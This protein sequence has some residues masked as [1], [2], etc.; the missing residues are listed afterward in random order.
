MEGGKADYR[1]SSRKQEGRN[2]QR[3]TDREIEREKREREAEREVEAERK[4]LEVVTTGRR[5]G[6]SL[7]LEGNGR[8]KVTEIR[9]STLPPLLITLRGTT[10]TVPVQLVLPSST[11]STLRPPREVEGSQ[12]GSLSGSRVY[13][14]RTGRKP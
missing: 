2:T 11:F 13:K 6:L 3:E 8:L 5:P 9:W 14:T 10:V 4:E 12:P 1:A 7:F